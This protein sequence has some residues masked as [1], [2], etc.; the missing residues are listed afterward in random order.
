MRIGKTYLGPPGAQLHARI[1]GDGPPVFLLH[2]S[3]LHGGFLAQ[4]IEALALAGFTAV[5]LDTPGFGGSDPLAETPASLAPFTDSVLGAANALGHDRFRLYGVATGAQIALETAKRA[6]DRVIRMTLDACGHFEPALIAA[7]EEDY[8]PDL[9]PKPD[10]SHLAFIWQMAKK[11]MTRFPWH[12]E[13]APGTAAAPDPPPEALAAVTLAFLQAGPRY[14]EA[15][16]LA[17]RNELASAFAGLTVPTVLIDWDSSIVRAQMLALI[18]QGLP[19]SVT[20]RHAGAG[21]PARLGA[22]V[23]S[24]KD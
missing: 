13:P 18:E 4:Q 24:F 17:F 2:P 8:F 20:V 22:L 10:G 5:A 15:Y 9:A 21:W 1:A 12:L 11:Q 23:S 16:R 19:P 7:W 6:P 14:R 3:P